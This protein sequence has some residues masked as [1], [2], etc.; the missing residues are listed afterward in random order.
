MH[1]ISSLWFRNSLSCKS[2]EIG[3]D[4]EEISQYIHTLLCRTMESFR[5]EKTCNEHS[6]GSYGHRQGWGQQL[7]LGKLQS[8]GKEPQT[9]CVTKGLLLSRG[10]QEPHAGSRALGLACQREKWCG[11]ACSNSSKHE[12]SNVTKHEM[13]NRYTTQSSCA[14]DCRNKGEGTGRWLDGKLFSMIR[15]AGSYLLN[16]S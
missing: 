8:A 2:L 11:W 12:M 15:A 16:S 10:T 13:S 3:L 5:L 14:L 4:H 1:G 6:T 9:P 7:H